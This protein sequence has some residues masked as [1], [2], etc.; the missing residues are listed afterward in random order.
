MSTIMSVAL[1]EG[2]KNWAR[3]TFRFRVNFGEAKVS[4]ISSL[5]V[6]KTRG[7][8]MV[9]LARV[10]LFSMLRMFYGNICYDINII[11]PHFG[12]Y[13]HILS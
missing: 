3:S 6:L 7:E 12:I 2:V 10:C 5:Q 13:I 1:R 11:E 9:R 4:L 8:V